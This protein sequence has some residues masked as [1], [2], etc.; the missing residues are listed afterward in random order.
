MPGIVMD[1]INEE[2]IVNEMNGNSVPMKENSV[3]NKSPR[4]TSSPHNLNSAGVDPPVD[5]VSVHG[6]AVDGVVDTSIEQLYEN[7]CDMQSSDQSP[8]PCIA[9]H[10]TVKSPGLIQSCAIW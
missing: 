1:G 7:V 10:L 6:V 5:A 9:L 2:A 4:N 3:P 8:T